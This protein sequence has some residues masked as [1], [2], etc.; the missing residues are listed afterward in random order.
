[1]ISVTLA[2]RY[3]RALLSLAERQKELDRTH[4]ELTGLASLVAKNPRIRNYF[5]SPNIS[6]A[7]KLSFLETSVK[8]KFGRLVYGLL[9]I[10]LRRRR[11]DHLVSIA[12]EFE[13]LAERAQGITRAM[14]RTAVPITD[15]QADALTRSLARRTGF[16]IL[17]TREVDA[18]LL[19]GAVVSLD[20]KVIDGTLATE[21]WRIRRYLLSTRVHGRG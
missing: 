20:H 18:T 15:G 6:R 12:A 19:G 5:E 17:L 8:P 1:V 2:R 14:I 9:Q 4:E 11:L 16:T 3:A 7:E 10:L 13:K 21:L